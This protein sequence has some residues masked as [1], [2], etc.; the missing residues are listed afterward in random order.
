[1]FWWRALSGCLSHHD[2]TIFKIAF[3]KVKSGRKTFTASTQ[4][5]TVSILSRFGCREMSTPDNLTRH[6]VQVSKFQFIMQPALAINAIKLGIPKVHTPFW[7]SI[8]L[9]DSGEL[10]QTYKALRASASKVLQMLKEPEFCNPSQERAYLF[11]RDFMGDMKP[12]EV[13]SF[14]RF[15]TVSV[16]YLAKSIQITLHSLRSLDKHLLP[17]ST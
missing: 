17:P 5:N 10:Y 4:S 9:G 3:D 14:L 15:V 1:M 7:D 13:Q 16:V 6:I 12:A 11:L 8:S 2:A